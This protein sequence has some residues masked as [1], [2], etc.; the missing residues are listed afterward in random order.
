VVTGEDC[1][2]FIH[3]YRRAAA[4]ERHLVVTGEDCEQFIHNYKRPAADERHLVVRTGTVNRSAKST[5]EQ[6][7][8]KGIL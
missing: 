3:N 8:M 5:E 6:L 1:E 4:D 2:Q 7:L